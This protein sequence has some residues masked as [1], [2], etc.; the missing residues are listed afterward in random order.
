MKPKVLFLDDNPNRRRAFQS[1]YPHA[2]IVENV[3]QCIDSLMSEDQWHT[4]SLDH[5][6]EGEI[7]VN[8]DRD[9]CGMEIVRYLEQL[10]HKREIGRIIVHSHNI[11]A[12]NEMALRLKACGYQA[13]CKLFD[14]WFNIPQKEE[15]EYTEEE[16]P[17][18]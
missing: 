7:F 18:E 9:D 11:D 15:L 16:T 3:E 10:D 4:V 6:L 8:S 17:E 1:R 14:E 2:T 13:E 5:D 12:A